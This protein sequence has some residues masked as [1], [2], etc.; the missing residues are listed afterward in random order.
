VACRPQAW[1]AGSTFM[2]LQACLGL[3]VHADRREV[4]IVR[5]TL[6]AAMPALSIDGLV[7]GDSKVDL[8]FQRIG[9]SVAV[10]PGPASDRTVSVVLEG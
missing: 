10:T 5:P 1:A 4:R 2:M 6:P 8:R 3:S 9:D 7:V